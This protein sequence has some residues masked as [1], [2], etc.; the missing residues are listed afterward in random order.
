MDVTKQML[1]DYKNM[2]LDL[3]SLDEERRY[4]YNTYRSPSF[5]SEGFG[6]AGNPSSPVERAQ[7]QLQRIDDKRD[8]LITEMHEIEEHVEMVTDPRMRS[9]LR[10]K[11]ILCYSWE[12]T[13]SIM[14]MSESHIRSCERQYFED[15]DSI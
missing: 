10:Y 11:Y 9:I 14:N 5:K 1:K 6:G 8:K 7:I 4:V 12:S 13:A 2:K 3:Q 15:H